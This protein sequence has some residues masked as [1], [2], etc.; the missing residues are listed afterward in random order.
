MILLCTKLPI[1]EEFTKADCLELYSNWVLKSKHYNFKRIDY[2]INSYEDYELKDGNDAFSIKNFKDDKIDVFA[3][4]LETKI[5]ETVWST[6]CVF[7]QEKNEKFMLVELNCNRLDYNS[8][9]PY[10]HKPYIIKN[11]IESN[12]CK[13]DC[14]I[15]ISDK[16]LYVEESNIEVCA[17]IMN[18]QYGNLLPVIYV[19]L[20]K[21]SCWQVNPDVLAREM[22]GLAHVFVEKDANVTWKLKE[23]TNSKNAYGGYIGIY[24]PQTTYKQLHSLDNH[25]GDSF[26]LQKEVEGTIWKALS[27]RQEASKYNWNQIT[28]MQYRQ[29]LENS[30]NERN[31][32]L[33]EYM[34]TFDDENNRLR[35]QNE[36]L[37][38]ENFE[39]KT[40]LSDLKESIKENKVK[41]NCFYLAGKEDTLYSSERND[42]LFSILSQVQ[43]KYEKNSRAYLLINSMLEA[44]PRD[45]ECGRVM[46]VINKIFKN[47]ENLGSAEKSQLKECGFI[48]EEDSAH[49]KLIF[50]DKRYM[51][52]V[53]K[54]PSDH[55]GGKNLKCN[56]GKIINIEKKIL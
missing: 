46:D 26:K 45:G 22:S 30:S 24:F 56:I 1:K 25:K 53:S 21:N 49:Y 38:K 19:S 32:E 50:H 23:N 33:Y 6:D 42:L 11:I 41:G 36:I 34:E 7:L 55:R 13:K 29:K 3:C 39:L 27:N 52:A 44:N 54:T 17:K 12:V 18:G 37:N 43:D 10:A 4:R 35:E 51:F 20:E 9:L 40:Y 16:P 5:A 47:G 28:T 14:D 8:N 48:I 31:Q 15:D 2:N